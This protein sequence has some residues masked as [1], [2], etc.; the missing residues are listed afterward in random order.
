MI[1]ILKNMKKENSLFLKV[2][3]HNTPIR[4]HLSDLL[5]IKKMRKI[6][7]PP[8]PPYEKSIEDDTTSEDETGPS[9]LPKASSKL[10]HK[11]IREKA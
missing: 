7:T 6:P 2:Y 5:G 1:L 11:I 9:I 3:V 4:L 8:I 10:I